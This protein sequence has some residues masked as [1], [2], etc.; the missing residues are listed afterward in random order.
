M[1]KI[2]FVIACIVLVFGQS[3]KSDDPF[4]GDCFIP[5]AGVSIT[6]NMD[7]PEY[8]NLRNLGEVVSFGEQ[9]NRGVYLIHNYDDVFYAIERT[10]PYQ[11][12]NACAQVVI[13]KDVLQYKCGQQVNDTTF[14]SCCG[15]TYDL[16]SSFLSGP[17]R[18]NLKTYRVAR[19]G[20]SLYVSN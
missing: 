10:C 4:T 6:I 8:Y 19:N 13:D 2:A 7:L 5:D 18:C 20:N 16:N 15:S 3:C 14:N 1:K 9:G 12:D 11:S 17:T